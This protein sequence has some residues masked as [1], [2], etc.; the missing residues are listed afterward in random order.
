M[1]SVAD[2]RATLRWIFSLEKGPPNMP[3]GTQACCP[4]EYHNTAT[5]EQQLDEIDGLL[6]DLRE[7]RAIEHRAA[8][9]LLPVKMDEQN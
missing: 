6:L 3:G 8:V 9:P 4:G 2:A 7:Q 5:P 1:R